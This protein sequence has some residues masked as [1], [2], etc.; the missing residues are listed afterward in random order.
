[1]QHGREESWTI[2]FN[3][4]V[5]QREFS[6]G[7]S[8]KSQG[9]GQHVEAGFV[10]PIR[11]CLLLC[12]YQEHPAQLLFSPLAAFTK[13]TFGDAQSNG[14]E[15]QGCSSNGLDMQVPCLG[16]DRTHYINLRNRYSHSSATLPDFGDKLLD[17]K[18]MGQVRHSFLC[19]RSE[20]S[21]LA[22]SLYTLG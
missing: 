17:L 9:L 12:A 6:N 4:F 15:L 7:Q 14:G 16:P 1:V 18:C 21:S 20:F 13:I 22:L 3:A 11:L 5:Q 10:Q 8:H 19:P 2:K